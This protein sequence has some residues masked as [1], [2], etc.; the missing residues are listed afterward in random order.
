MD[1]FVPRDTVL[2][3]TRRSPVESQG[4][5][6]PES[7]DTEQKGDL[8]PWDERSNALQCP[9]CHTKYLYEKER[10]RKHPL[11]FSCRARFM[12]LD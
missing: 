2:T 10:F 4:K 8:L 12:E 5:T 9:P 1:G 11:A 3:D 6:K 7:Y